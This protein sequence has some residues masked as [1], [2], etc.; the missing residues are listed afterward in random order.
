[1]I[2]NGKV[3]NLVYSLTNAEGEILDSATE[4]DPFTYLHGASQIVPGLE[5]GL[6][7]LKIG[8]KKKIKVLA[9]DGYGEVDPNLKLS[10][11]RS[12]FPKEMQIEPGMQFETTSPDGHG[13]VFTIES[14]EGD[15][16]FIDGNHPMAGQDL[17]FSIEVVAV[18][19]ASAEEL[20]HGHAHGPD[21]HGHHH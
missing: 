10:V 7:G 18:R 2:T 1:M 19:D 21:G 12:Q 16:V 4:S 15:K 11:N 14:V 13:M 20:E 17:N 9:K 5:A 8:D 6:E 3:V